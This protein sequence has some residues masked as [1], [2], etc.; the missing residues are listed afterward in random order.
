MGKAKALEQD[1]V[2]QRWRW[3]QVRECAPR[4][5]EDVGL[6]PWGT[7]LELSH[8]HGEQLQSESGAEPA[9]DGDSWVPLPRWNVCFWCL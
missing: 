2:P 1:R 5:K 4:G 9:A 8:L 6:P 3:S 7:G